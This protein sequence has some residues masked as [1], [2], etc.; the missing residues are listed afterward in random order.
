MLRCTTCKSQYFCTMF[1][2]RT[3]WARFSARPMLRASAQDLPQSGYTPTPTRSLRSSSKR[4]C[5]NG[6][7]R[8]KHDLNGNMQNRQRLLFKRLRKEGWN[9][10][11]VEQDPRAKNYSLIRANKRI[12]FVFRQRGP[13]SL[14]KVCATLA[15]NSSKFPMHGTKE[16]LNV[17][18]AA[19]II[20][21]SVRA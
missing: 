20:L 11:G 15:T 12:V 19:G 21:F 10:V 8:E 9:I 17:S 4:Y 5:Q 16:S 6:T 7:W 1:E 3:M 14:Q 18:V 2:A 13:R